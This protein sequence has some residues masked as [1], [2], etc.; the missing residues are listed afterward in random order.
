MSNTPFFSSFKMPQ[1]KKDT[2]MLG[3]NRLGWSVKN[4]TILPISC[5]NKILLSRCMASQENIACSCTSLKKSI[6]FVISTVNCN[7]GDES[8]L[9]N[10]KRK[11]IPEKSNKYLHK[12][13]EELQEYF[14]VK[15]NKTES[16]PS[17]KEKI[18]FFI[19]ASLNLEA[20][21][22]VHFFEVNYFVPSPSNF[23]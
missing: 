16:F 3:A 9:K 6:T 14:H 7:S 11:Q 15:N 2:W 17:E 19:V 1:E 20:H 4:S 18:L 12:K 10:D 13:V 21:H 22:S 8:S 23:P 5:F